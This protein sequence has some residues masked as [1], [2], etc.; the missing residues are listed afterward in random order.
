[1][2]PERLSFQNKFIPSP[3]IS[4][5]LFVLHDS[6]TKF[7]PRTIWNSSTGVS[8]FRSGM[9]SYSGIMKTSQKRT[10]FRVGN[11]NQCSLARY[12]RLIGCHVNVERKFFILGRDSLRNEI[13]SGIM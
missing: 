4:L 10:P 6:E 11:R 5:H 1:M 13:H 9:T 12:V 8:S 3:C 7:R 2:I